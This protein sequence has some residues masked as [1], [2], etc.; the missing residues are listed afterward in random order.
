MNN[1]NL[2]KLITNMVHFYI[3][4]QQEFLDLGPDVN[5]NEIS[6]LLFRMLQQIHLEGRTT[7]STLSKRV[8]VSLP[9]T[10]RNINKLIQLGYVTKKQDELD[11][12]ITHLHLTNKGF[13]LVSN[14]ILQS[15]EKLFKKYNKLDS[16]EIEKLNESFSTIRK[17]FIKLGTLDND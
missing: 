3:L 11:K 15:E 12:R 14:A 8:S 7:V 6:P 1:E 13:D 10:S 17:S 2:D 5:N 4:F 9:N 16:D